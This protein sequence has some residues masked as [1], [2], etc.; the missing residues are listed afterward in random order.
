MEDGEY[1]VKTDKNKREIVCV[2]TPPHGNPF[3]YGIK[4]LLHNS[5]FLGENIT[6]TTKLKLPI[7]RKHP[8]SKYKKIYSCSP[9]DSVE[10]FGKANTN[11]AIP[12][13]IK[14]CCKIN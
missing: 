1:F 9:F 10:V 7:L 5:A 4:I 8:Y 6:E 14:N 3:V 13:I 11:A 2:L 12:T